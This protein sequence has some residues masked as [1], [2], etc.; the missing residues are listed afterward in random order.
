MVSRSRLF[1]YKS[2]FYRLKTFDFKQ[3]S[4][5][6]VTRTQVP[7]MRLA[8]LQ[9]LTKHRSIRTVR[10]PE[11]TTTSSVSRWPL[12]YFSE[13]VPHNLSRMGSSSQTLRLHYREH[14]TCHRP[15]PLTN[16]AAYQSTQNTPPQGLLLFAT[17][18]TRVHHSVV[19]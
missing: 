13:A 3:T 4:C 6:S 14:S 11:P 16:L 1:S 12:R 19:S 15:A 8:T 10:L 9:S 18:T 2:D 5:G 7:L 17:S